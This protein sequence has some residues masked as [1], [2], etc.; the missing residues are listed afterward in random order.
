MDII[1][2]VKDELS[3]YGQV[4]TVVAPRKK[5]QFPCEGN[6]FVEFGNPM[7]AKTAAASLIGRRFAERTVTVSYYDEILFGNRQLI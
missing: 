1:E 4:S 5:D 3:Q 2:D 6:I 7:H